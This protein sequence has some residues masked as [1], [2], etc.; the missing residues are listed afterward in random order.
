MRTEGALLDHT[1]GAD[2]DLGVQP[3]HH[4]LGPLGLEPVE[5]LDGVGTRHRAVTTADAARIDL[6]HDPGFLALVGGSR[7]ADRDAWR[8]FAVVRAEF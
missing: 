6:P 3:G 4:F 1:L 8:R 2:R 7:R 5:I